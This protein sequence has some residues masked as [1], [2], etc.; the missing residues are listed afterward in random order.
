MREQVRDKSRLEHIIEAIDFAI[1]FTQ[2]VSFDEYQ[3]NNMMR[4]AVVK[5]LEILGEASYKLTN[6]FT[7]AHSEV[8]W[9]TIIKLRH[10]LVHGYYQ[11][12]DIVIWEIVQNDLPPLKEQIQNIY[13]NL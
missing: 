3:K 5:N 8:E 11:L 4:F 7:T 10:V 6:E 2:G 1:E 12:E 13:N 9:K